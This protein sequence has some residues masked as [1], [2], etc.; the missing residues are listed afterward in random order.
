MRFFFYYFFFYAGKFE[1]MVLVVLDEGESRG[2]MKRSMSFAG[3]VDV[4]L[5]LQAT[6]EGQRPAPTH[7]CVARPLMTLMTTMMVGIIPQGDVR[8][9]NDLLP[10]WTNGGNVCAR[11]VD[12]RFAIN[13]W[14]NPNES[15]FEKKDPPRRQTRG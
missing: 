15:R 12:R 8:V 1:S 14:E 11:R 7:G 9:R 4:G 2:G 10:R 6:S 5:A 3:T 13:T